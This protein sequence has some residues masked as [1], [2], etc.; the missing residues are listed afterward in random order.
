MESIFQGFFQE[1]LAVVSHDIPPYMVYIRNVL[2]PFFLFPFNA[3]YSSG[4]IVVC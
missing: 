3:N 1:R 2:A 4:Y